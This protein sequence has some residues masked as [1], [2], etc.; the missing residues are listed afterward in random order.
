MQSK[1]PFTQAIVDVIL[2]ALSLNA[3]SVAPKL[4]M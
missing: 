2:V 1:S 4:A 3:T